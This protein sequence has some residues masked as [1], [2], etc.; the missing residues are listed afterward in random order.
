VESI[1]VLAAPAQPTLAMSPSGRPEAALVAAALCPDYA[2]FEAAPARLC[3][4]R[5]ELRKE[6]AMP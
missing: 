4:F 3:G 5:F 6:W 1:S 2:D